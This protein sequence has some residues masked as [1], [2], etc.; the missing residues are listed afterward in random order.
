MSIMRILIVKTSSLGDVIHTLPALTDALGRIPEIRFDWV[1]EEVFAEVPHWHPGVDRVIAV[2]LRRWRRQPLRAIAKGEWKTCRAL[3]RTHCYDK[4]IDAQGLLKSAL[5]ARIARGPSHGLDRRS[6]REPL[7]SLLYHRRHRVP[8]RQHAI[9]RVRQLF[10]HALDYTLPVAMPDYGIR[11]TSARGADMAKPYI[12][13]LHGTTWMSKCWPEP[14][15]VQLAHIVAQSGYVVRL[16]WGD[17]DEYARAQRI[18]HATAN[19]E[20]LPSMGLGDMAAVL[21][22]ATGVVA[23]D[24]GLGHLAAALG[25]PSVTVY[26]ATTPD[27]T[28]TRGPDQLCLRAQF[29][30][31]P[32]LKRVCAYA[33]DSPVKPAC[34]ASLPAE[35][36]WSALQGGSRVE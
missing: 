33:G 21:R 25:V 29:P 12:V 4:V 7:A 24:T 15:W 26:G 2:A 22:H 3:L 30:C 28:G 13:F 1:V 27:W 18:A 32:C 34:Y 5:I 9:E 17:A 11:M 23:V 35:Q 10:A 16:P 31:S 14:Y 6:A 8:W 36:V 20:I 19:A